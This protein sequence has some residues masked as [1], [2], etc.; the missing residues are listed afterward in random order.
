MFTLEENDADYCLYV[1][2]N[3]ISRGVNREH[4]QAEALT[5]DIRFLLSIPSVRE[6][7]HRS[8][9]D[10]GREN[11]LLQH[12]IHLGNEAAVEVLMQLPMVS[13]LAEEN[14]HYRV[15]TSNAHAHV[16]GEQ[17]HTAQR[18]SWHSI[19]NE[20][21]QGHLGIGDFLGLGAG[22]S[23]SYEGTQNDEAHTDLARQAAN[24]AAAFLRPH[25]PQT[26]ED[27]I[28]VTVSLIDA[29]KAVPDA[30]MR[31]KAKFAVD[32]L[33]RDNENDATTQLKG[34][35]LA[36][37]SWNYLQSLEGGLN[38]AELNVFLLGLSSYSSLKF[39]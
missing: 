5:D 16:A 24:D 34:R 31:R 25:L 35:A 2:R 36:I 13:E 26:K 12:A 20:F 37:A 4:A 29:I 3:L 23:R 33:L 27:M 21:Q 19:F 1:L 8:F 15:E 30:D 22:H 18:E 9:G 14:N 17:L 7:T 38:E 32:R 10:N 6:K 11:Q 39:K 28:S